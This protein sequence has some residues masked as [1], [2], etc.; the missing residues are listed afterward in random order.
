MNLHS[1]EPAAVRGEVDLAGDTQ[2][3][4]DLSAAP[5]NPAKV[6][7]RIIGLNHETVMQ[8]DIAAPLFMKLSRQNAAPL[9][10][11]G[12]AASRWPCCLPMEASYHSS[13]DEGRK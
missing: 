7:H 8:G 1:N 13:A 3:L 6:L 2:G 12:T 9:G 11:S 5:P 10:Q 4:V